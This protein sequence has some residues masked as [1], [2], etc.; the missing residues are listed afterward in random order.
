MGL[1]GSWFPVRKS[2]QAMCSR[3]PYRWDAEEWRWSEIGQQFDLGK[4][5]HDL[6]FLD[7]TM[8]NH[9]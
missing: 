9:V 2:F 3:A 1:N 7:R 5:H 8:M 6:T 4:F